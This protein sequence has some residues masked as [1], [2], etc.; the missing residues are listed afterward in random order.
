MNSG[1]IDEAYAMVPVIVSG[2]SSTVGGLVGLNT[3]TGTVAQTFSTGYVTAPAGSDVGGLIGENDNSASAIT[4]SYFDMNTSGQATAIATGTGANS[5][6]AV[7]ETTQALQNGLPVSFTASDWGIVAGTSYPYLHWQFPTTPPQVISGF[8]GLTGSASSPIPTTPVAPNTTV[9]VVVNGAS[10]IS[11]RGK[12]DTL[13]GA[14]GYYYFLL[15]PG[16]VAPN[17]QVLVYMPGANFGATFID[18]SQGNETSVGLLA[19][20]LREITAGLSYSAVASDLLTA[21]G[22]APILPQINALP[23]L[24]IKANGPSFT[25]DRSITLPGTITVLSVG[26][27]TLGVGVTLTSGAS[28]DAVVLSSMTKFINDAGSG[29]IV[30]TG[31]GRWLIYSSAPGGDT[32][33]GLNSNNTAV[34]DT[35]YPTPVGKAGNRYVFAFQPAI[36]VTSGDVK[37][38]EGTDATAAVTSD[39]TISG[40]QPGV[41]NAFLGDTAA[42]VYSGTPT[43]T[44]AG[45]APSASIVG[46][47]YPIVVGAGSLNVG[48][49]YAVNLVSTGLLTITPNPVASNP[50]LTSFVAQPPSEPTPPQPSDQS[51]P[52]DVVSPDNSTSGETTSAGGRTTTDATTPQDST[53]YVATAGPIASM[54]DET[55]GTQ[56]DTEQLPES[57]GA[58]TTI[59]ESLNWHPSGKRG[60]AVV[61]PGLLSQQPPSTVGKASSGVPSPDQVFSSWGNEAL[62]H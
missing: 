40:I 57:D 53:T 61:I 23:N 32:F 21:V 6:G 24:V 34:W 9:L 54:T 49:G 19:G 44:S 14:N 52:P 30:L 5:A 39:Y 11:I 13:T 48:D 22:S 1:S 25:L 29:A 51:P 33:G 45:S 2:T 47:P 27:L 35:T 17:S 55:G 41:A 28:G 26:D 46:S 3:S 38:V 62:W 36:T 16:S 8:A 37:K 56:D 15:A 20:T 60:K 12:N 59:S 58:A 4:A 42:S 31:T 50:V 18:N 10:P 43:V 7:G